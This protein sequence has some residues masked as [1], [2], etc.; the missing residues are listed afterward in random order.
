MTHRHFLALRLLAA[1][2]V[3]G[4]AA[5]GART[6]ALGATASA[7]QPTAAR[8]MPV[9]AVTLRRSQQYERARSYTGQLVAARRSTLSFQRAGKVDSL[10]VDEGDAV[11][12]AQPL[13]VLDQRRLDARR[14]ETAARLAEARAAL[15]ELVSGPRQQTIAASAAEVRS[16]QATQ[17]IAEK[18]LERR[19]R[20]VD[21][22]AISQEEF[23]ESL[24]DVRAATART[25]A[26]QKSLDELEAGT[27]SEQVDAQR[28]R[29]AALEASLAD[30]DH[31][32]E[33]SILNAP[34]AGRVA[35]RMVDEGSVVAT[36]EGV[37]ELVSDTLEAWIGAPPAVAATLR[38]GETYPLSVGGRRMKGKLRSLRP[39][40][41]PSTRTRNVVFEIEGG[42][43]LVDGQVARIELTETI[44][45]PGFW[46][47]T[48][49]LAPQQ[50][51]L[52]AVYVVAASEDAEGYV[53]E[54]RDVEVLHTDGDRSYV[55]GLLEEG[56]RVVA[57]GVH[58]V[59]AGQHVAPKVGK[60]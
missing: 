29:V 41:D 47:P 22:R 30:V 16:L 1:L 7:D 19:R 56:D 39:E 59:V 4:A 49:A 5:W 26:A 31:E 12:A 53:L 38:V 45:E 23:D 15:A 25:D 28:A 6:L 43:G 9:E 57:D 52:W 8:S 54:S 36:G 34:Y 21:T 20:L 32:L 3:V 27:R 58:R 50:R 55:R 17:E 42:Y 10:S 13:A 18:N 46:V 37:I 24:Y 14:A 51:G 48:R 2:L 35:R 33:D 40:L 11:E 44:D 60:S